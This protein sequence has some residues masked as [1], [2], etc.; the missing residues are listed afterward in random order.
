MLVNRGMEIY[1][2]KELIKLRN[3]LKDWENEDRQMLDKPLAP[4]LA[5]IKGEFDCYEKESPLN[6][7]LAV[8]WAIQNG[9]VQQGAT[10]LEE[11]VTTFILCDIGQQEMLNHETKRS[12]A[13]AALAVGPEIPFT[14]TE[15][16]PLVEDEDAQAK[17]KR[18]KAQ[19]NK[20][21]EEV[22]VPIIRALPYK[23]KL[24]ECVNSI[25]NSIRNDINHAGFRESPRTYEEL[26]ASLTKRYNEIRKILG[27][28]EK[29]SLPE[30]KAF[31]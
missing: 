13:S 28:A 14:Y 7:F 27:N 5:K 6:G 12:K 20:D 31:S 19:E 10:L 30:L 8:K 11:A 22:Y 9:L 2:G 16:P 26:C 29:L 24:A 4:I 17:A 18:E 23:K 25:K 21:W 3:A 15:V 1:D